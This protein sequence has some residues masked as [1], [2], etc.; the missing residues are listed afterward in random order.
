MAA[1]NNLKIN[2][3]RQP[4]ERKDIMIY[5][6]N[7]NNNNNNYLLLLLLLLLLLYLTRV[8]NS[9]QQFSVGP[10]LTN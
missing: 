5:N 10:S 3:A 6:N 8:P 2:N 4:V 9:P 1:R 7:N